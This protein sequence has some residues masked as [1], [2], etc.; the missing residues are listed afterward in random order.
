MIEPVAPEADEYPHKP[1]ALWTD[2]V[3]LALA[4]VSVVLVA[5][6]TFFPV[7]DQTYRFIRI[8]DY[9]ICAVFAAEFLWRWRRE[10][11]S[12]TFPFVYWYEVLGMIPVT[13]PFF[14]GFRL[15]RV[16]VIAVRV[17]RVADRAFGDRITAAVV[18][19]S[20]GAIVD[21]IKRPVTIAVLEEVAEVLRTG[22]YTRNIAS[23]LEENRA[24]IDQMILE[25]IRNDPQ[26]GKVRYVP[27]HEEM[28]RGIADAS[29][30]VIFQVLADPR[31]DELVADA[32]R[33]NID[34][35][36]E[37]VHAGERVPEAIDHRP[38]PRT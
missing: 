14:R 35:I 4:V 32:L 15:L 22:H 28:I 27:F 33:E 36:R 18:N 9:S 26:L 31:T 16:V 5:W 10:G 24:E 20:V 29:F 30:R 6:V 13:S 8:A 12:W 23:A 21:A 3:M 38:V 1:P 11:W 17:G 25:V 34:Q 19:R 7:A 2:F 37:A